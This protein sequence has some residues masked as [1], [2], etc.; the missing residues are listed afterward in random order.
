MTR[1][2]NGFWKDPDFPKSGWVLSHIDDL[3]EAD[4]IC[5]MCQIQEIRYVHSIDHADYAF[6]LRVGCICAGKLTGNPE[7]HF[8]LEG[9]L[10]RKA[11]QRKAWSNL[12][13]WKISAK[14][15]PYIFKDDVLVVLYS[16][17][18]QWSFSV[19]G[20]RS[21]RWYNTQAQVEVA[22]F[23]GYWLHRY[24]HTCSEPAPAKL[25]EFR[26]VSEKFTIP[27]GM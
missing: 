13:S 5:E 20:I 25:P 1:A 9:V 2:Q 14:G 10:R 3:G 11:S 17:G 4:E 24:P 16:G 18:Q 8:D 19:G 6:R 23:E 12:K 27:V 7:R 21:N 15:N 22:A 26:Y